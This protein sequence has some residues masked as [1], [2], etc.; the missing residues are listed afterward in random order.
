[1]MREINGWLIVFLALFGFFSVFEIGID[2]DTWFLLNHGRFVEQNG[3]PHVEPFTIHS[4]FHFVMQQWLFAL[5]IWKIY[6]LFGIAGLLGFSYIAGTIIL[7]IYYKILQIISEG[8]TR[9]SV[10]MTAIVGCLVLLMFVKQRPQVASTA[11]FLLEIYML[12]KYHKKEKPPYFI[13]VTF[14]LLSALLINVHAAMWPLFVI[15]MIPYLVEIM[16]KRKASWYMCNLEWDYKPMVIL[17]L[18][19]IIA[20]FINPYGIE[21]MTYTIHSYGYKE[22]NSMVAEMRP[23][24]L[25]GALSSIGIII[26]F[27]FTA[28]YA[29]HKLPLRYLLLALGTGYMAASSIRS[30]FLFLVVGTLPLAYILKKWH[31]VD[32]I[33]RIS[34]KKFCMQGGLMVVVII[35]SLYEVAKSHLMIIR[36]PLLSILFMIFG[37]IAVHCMY[38]AYRDRHSAVNSRVRIRFYMCLLVLYLGSLCIGLKNDMQPVEKELAKSVDILLSNNLASEI[39]LWT[40]YDDGNYLEFH[41]IHC[42][43]DTR[44]EVFLP[45][46][47]G[48][49]NVLYEYEKLLSGE[50]DYRE[51]AS[52]YQFTHFLTRGNDI[53]YTY[54]ASDP[55]YVLL[56]DSQTDVETCGENIPRHEWIRIYEYAPHK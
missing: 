20:G 19:S 51:F 11:I 33:K 49:K 9:I 43:I 52:R 15:F 8:N 22:I 30:L 1:M 55:D 42:Y 39:S 46:L 31:Q 28:I 36:W 53:L 14:F 3:F 27:C 50:L 26:L 40:N 12:E 24:A 38:I 34:W 16:A 45:E 13:Y 37:G 25:N 44:A 17:I 2:N 7:L 29:Q 54:L 18:I 10:E 35:I 47:N 4:N 23:L 56:W 6:S 41:G 32:T 21:S 5:G 48:Q